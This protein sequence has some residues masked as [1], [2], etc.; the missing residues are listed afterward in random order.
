MLGILCTVMVA[1]L[2]KKRDSR[3]GR[4]IEEEPQINKGLEHLPYK[5]GL[6]HFGF[7]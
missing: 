2:K 3:A 5:T 6:K 4:G 1:P 7:L